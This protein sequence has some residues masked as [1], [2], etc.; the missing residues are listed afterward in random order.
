MDIIF[1]ILVEIRRSKHFQTSS[2]S[3]KWLSLKFCDRF[4]F[5][6]LKTSQA[7]LQL[8]L[9]KSDM[10]ESMFWRQKRDQAPI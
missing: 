8:R 2:Y 1:E 3:F 7:N 9:T 5:E 6:R 4:E 10:P